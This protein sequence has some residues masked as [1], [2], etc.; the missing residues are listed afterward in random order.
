MRAF[1]SMGG[2]LPEKP[3]EGAALC[4]GNASQEGAAGDGGPFKPLSF[5]GLTLPNNVL[6]A[7]M[8]G[9]T[10]LA[11]R[12]MCIK[13][14]AGL[15]FTEMVSSKGLLYDNMETKKL[16]RCGEESPKAAQLFGS[17]PDVLR[18]ACESGLLAPYDLID[19]NMG[20]PMPK[21]VRNGE[22]SALLENMPLAEKVIS[23]CGSAS[24]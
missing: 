3:Q 20:C 5:A 11:Y 9:Y 12:R 21:I 6:L 15:T 13:L 23:A 14:G 4:A 1:D 18:A 7:P 2:V 8:A 19:L 22:G 10:D 24:A 17:D 16:L